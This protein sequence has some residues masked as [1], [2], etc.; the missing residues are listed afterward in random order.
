MKKIES[1]DDYIRDVKE[2]KAKLKGNWCS[3]VFRELSEGIN[4]EAQ[5]KKLKN[6]IYN[7]SRLRVVDEH[8][9]EAMI[10]QIQYN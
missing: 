8:I 5:K 10:R 6:R 2:V 4:D 7:V 3:F 9:L 1:K